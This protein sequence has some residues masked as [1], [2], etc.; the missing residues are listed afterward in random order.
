M[1]QTDIKGCRLIMQE[2]LK[3]IKA[4]L[5][6]LR[7][8]VILINHDILKVREQLDIIENGLRVKRQEPIG[9]APGTPPPDFLPPELM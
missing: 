1:G 5:L 3:E 2:L 7:A 8:D 9:I 4:E 6:L